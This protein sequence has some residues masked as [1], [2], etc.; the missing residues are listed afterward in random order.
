[1]VSRPLQL[2]LRRRPAVSLLTA[3]VAWAATAAFVGAMSDGGPPRSPGAP[4]A[5]RAA[6]D[7]IVL[8]PGADPSRAMA[9]A[10]RTS[11]EQV[12][13]EAQLARAVDGPTL[14]ET[15][16][17]VRGATPP[18]AIASRNGP[19]LYHHIR[20]SD[21]EPDTVYAYRLKGAEGW[22]EWFQFKTAANAA[23]PFRFLYL[24]D[25]QNGILSESSRVLRQAFRDNGG[26]ELVLHAGDLVDQRD[27]L[28]HDDEWGEWNAAAG[29][30][31]AVIPQIPAA[32]N[33]EYDNVLTPVPNAR[34]RLGSY[35]PLQFALPDNGAPSA[36][37]TTY[38]V[39][40]QNVRF[41]VLDGT[42]A[43]DLGT[44]D[45]QARWLDRTLARSKAAWNVVIFHQPIFSC[46]RP[47]DSNDLNTVWKPVLERRKVDL[48]L[49]GHDHCYRRSTAE[50][51][52]GPRV[53]DDSASE[54]AVPVYMVSVAGAKMYGLNDRAEGEM[55]RAAEATQ[56]YQIVDVA[57]DQLSVRVYTA[58]GRLYDGFDI[59][60]TH[61][62]RKLVSETGALIAER[63]CEGGKGPDGADCGVRTKRASFF[64]R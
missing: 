12:S 33:H 22:S 57:S 25:M 30:Q 32:G 9:V 17:V 58:T 7:R 50:Q 2:A 54:A 40:Y 28:D 45:D 36:T 13:S 53:S 26:I 34:R 23:R 15:A 60:R 51:Q 47:E 56:L 29:Y 31:Y 6:P 18:R 55:D 63:R 43:L 62:G 49:Q 59:K 44:L 21:L 20:F 61:D 35:W 5:P 52:Q 27:D 14:E 46:A 11:A 24:G 1:M 19:A 48:V 10:Y 38:F 42:S 16:E 37:A 41:I 3:A 39:D 4:F 64:G 8:T